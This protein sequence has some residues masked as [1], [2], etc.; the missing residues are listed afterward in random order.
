MFEASWR[1]RD[2]AMRY[3]YCA[4]RLVRRT[5]AAGAACVPSWPDRACR[6]TPAI[7]GPAVPFPHQKQ[8][9]KTAPGRPRREP[10]MVADLGQSPWVEQLAPA[11]DHGHGVNEERE[12][13]ADRAVKSEQERKRQDEL[14]NAQEV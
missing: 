12:A 11:H 5:G 8:R 13:V 6:R 4:L 1:R 2:G 9:G 3:A 7:D 10:Q 14:G